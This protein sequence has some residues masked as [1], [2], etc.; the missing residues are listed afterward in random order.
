[1]IK[2]TPMLLALL[3]L[4]GCNK[5]GLPEH[6]QS[7]KAVIMYDDQGPSYIIVG[8]R[9]S[10]IA[11]FPVGSREQFERFDS[12]RISRDCILTPFLAKVEGVYF[13]AVRSRIDKMTIINRASSDSIEGSDFTFRREYI[14]E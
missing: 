10:R 7:E 6:F 3:T 4:I 9:S 5:A 13:D 8:K 11:E 14:C 12:Q 1:M 2:A